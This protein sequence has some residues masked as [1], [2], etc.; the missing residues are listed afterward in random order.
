MNKI[1]DAFKKRNAFVAFITAGDPNLE[2]T[3]ELIISMAEAGADLIE[4]GLPFSDPVAEGPVI[5]R[6]SQRALLAGTTT[7]RIFDILSG[8]K[9]SIKVPLAIMTYIN[10]VFK[11]GYESFFKKCNEC[12]ICGIIIPDLPYEEHG[13][14]LPYCK[15]YGVSLISMIA[16]TSEERIS[17]IA[18]RSEGF[19]YCVS[20][21]GVTGIRSS[22]DTKIN[23][24]ISSIR[25]V[26][27]SPVALGFGI[28]TPEQAKELIKYSDGIIV[29]SSIVKIIEEHG[30]ACIEPVCRYVSTMRNACINLDKKRG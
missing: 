20:S 25:S 12:G 4:L 2:T 15:R 24:V 28:S 3:R 7:D 29:G 5:Q 26:S 21:M 8:I 9:G 22:F 13:E 10:P 17:M 19:I 27:T 23:E 14:I 6:A 11:Y 16:P 30:E 1:S 18:T